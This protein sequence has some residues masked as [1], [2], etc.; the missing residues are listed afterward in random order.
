MRASLVCPGLFSICS[1]DPHLRC[2]SRPGDHSAFEMA[3]ELKG[4]D[5]WANPLD[6]QNKLHSRKENTFRNQ[7]FLEQQQK[8]LLVLVILPGCHQLTSF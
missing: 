2:G 1:K 4:F 7:E 5:T 3:G 8:G 6:L